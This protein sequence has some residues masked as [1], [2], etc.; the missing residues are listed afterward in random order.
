MEIHLMQV[1]SEGADLSAGEMARKLG[2]S[3]IESFLKNLR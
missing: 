2:I 1:I 3:N